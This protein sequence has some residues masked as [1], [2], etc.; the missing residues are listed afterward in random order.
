MRRIFA[1]ARELMSENWTGGPVR[2]LGVSVS[3]LEREA[4]ASQAE[5]FAGDQRMKRLTEALDRVRDRLGEAS[6]V[7][8]G[9]LNHRR[10]LGHVPFGA[11]TPR[12][13]AAT[14]SGVRVRA[15]SRSRPASSGEHQA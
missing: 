1:V 4:S 11:V 2:L 6:L 13:P 5:L 3:G 8:A 12:S 9:T 15:G 10:D 14:R 7:P